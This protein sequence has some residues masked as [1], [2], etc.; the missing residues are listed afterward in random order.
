MQQIAFS[1]PGPVE[2]VLLL[3]ILFVP[4]AIILVIIR[5]SRRT[6]PP[7]SAFPV[8]DPKEREEKAP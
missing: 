4:A 2:M 6:P 8:I 1:M 5:A 3:A 7:P